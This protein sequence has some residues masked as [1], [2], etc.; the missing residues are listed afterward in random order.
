[1]SRLTESQ[2]SR[3]R[4]LAQIDEV[5]EE[6][7]SR[8]DERKK[9]SKEKKDCVKGNANHGEDGRFSKKGSGSS[10]SKHGDGQSSDDCKKGQFRLS[11]KRKLITKGKGR[12]GREDRT[13]PNKK[14]EYKCKDATL[15]RESANDGHQRD[16]DLAGDLKFALD[17]FSTEFSTRTEF[18]RFIDNLLELLKMIPT[19]YGDEGVAAAPALNN[20]RMNNHADNADSVNN[21][22]EPDPELVKERAARKR[23]NKKGM[24]G[25]GVSREVA[26]RECGRFGLFSFQHFLRVLNQYESAKKAT[27]GKQS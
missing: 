25:E 15:N 21:H 2:K 3:M 1:V 11:G 20:L 5:N 13:N 16:F 10:W 4:L 7:K 8:L 14:G 24:K 26:E 17:V 22:A 6:V 12:C 23:K 9:K 19:H 27:L 18:H